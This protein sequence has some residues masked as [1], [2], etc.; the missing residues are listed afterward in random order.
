MVGVLELALRGDLEDDQRED[1]PDDHQGGRDRRREQRRAERARDHP[2]ETGDDRADR[3][4][5]RGAFERS[6]TS[7]LR[8]ADTH[9]PRPERFFRSTPYLGPMDAGDWV[10]TG[11]ALAGGLIALVLW[12]G[13]SGAP[14]SLVFVG[15][16]VCGSVLATAVLAGR[17]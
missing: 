7:R 1:D 16:L 4:G 15:G 6:D 9:G 3:D 14:S 17:R 11:A 5:R 13:Q 8:R 10:A 2:P 12:G